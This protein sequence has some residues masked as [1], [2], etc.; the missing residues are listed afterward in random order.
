MTTVFF[1]HSAHV[2]SCDLCSG[3]RGARRYAD[4]AF[5]ALGPAQLGFCAAHAVARLPRGP[6]PV[7]VLS[8]GGRRPAALLARRLLRQPAAATTTAT[9]RA[10]AVALSV[11][12]ADSASAAAAA[13]TAAPIAH[14]HSAAADQRARH[15]A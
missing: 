10:A 15:V 8:P 1:S 6:C 12:R 11:A 13:A 5:R 7:A 3:R 9:A 4:N 2:T 14:A